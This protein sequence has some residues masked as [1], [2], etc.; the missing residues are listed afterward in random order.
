MASN[1]ETLLASILSAVY[2]KDVRQSI[3]DAIAQCYDDVSN[4]DL[5]SEAFIKAI[6]EKIDDGSIAK[7]TLANGAVTTELLADGSVTTAKIAVGAVTPDEIKDRS[8][9]TNKLADG[10]VTEEKLADGAVTAKKIADGTI[11]GSKFLDGSVSA[12][13][14]AN[15]SV[16]TEKL[17]N[18]AVTEEKLAD[19]AVGSGKL[20]AGSVTEEK[21][22]DGAVESGKL[23]AGSVTTEKVKDGAI[24][25]EKLASSFRERIKDDEKD[26]EQLQSNVKS[27]TNNITLLTQ[28][29]NNFANGFTIGEDGK[30]YLTH[31]G[32]I[33][34]NG[35]DIATGGSG[36]AGLAFNGGYMSEDGYLHLTQDGE[37]IDGFDPIYIGT[38]GGGAA[39]SKLVFA[40]YTAS[41]FSVLQTS[42]TAPIKFRFSSVDAT[43]QTETGAGN[44]SIYVGGILKENRTVDQGDNISI[45]V[46]E[47]LAAGSNTVKLVMTD[48]YG[49]TATRTLAITLESF[50]LEWNLGKTEKNSGPLVVYVTPTGSGT[51]RIYLLVDGTQTEMQEVTTTG[52]R[53]S[54]SVPLTI[55]AH[56]ISV[57]GT[58]TI[59][60]VTLT[61][62]TLTCAVA[63]TDESDDTVVIAANLQIE[64]TE[65]YSTLSIPYRVIDPKN[66]PT[67]VTFY[68]DEVE[69]ASDEVDQSEHV[70]SYRTTKSGTLTLGIACGGEEWTKTIEVTAL[71]SEIAEVTDNLVLKVDPNDITDLNAF[72]YEGID[73]SFS[74]N[75]DTHNGGLQTDEEGIRCIKV[76]KGDR[77]V[78]NYNLFGTDARLN[79]RAFKFIYKIMNCSDFFAEAITCINGNIGLSI[80]ANDVAVTTEQTSIALETCE[81]YKTELELNIEPDSENRIMMMWE[82]GV[83]SAAK[84]Y[85][86][87]DNLKQT[88][89]VGITVGSDYCDVF[90]YL[91]RVYSRDLTKEEIKANYYAD[92]KDAAEITSRYDRNQVY[93]GSGKL[94]PDK[95]AALNPGVHV[96][97]WHAS[98]VSTAKSQEIT[99]SLTHKYVKGG[100]SH[101]WTAENVV[102]KAQGTSSLGYVDAGCNED[103]NLKEG[104]TLEDG[105]HQDVYS[106]TDDSIGVSYFNFKTNVASQE[107]INNIMVADHYNS[108][109]PYTRWAK[110]VNGKV[111]DTVEGHMAVMFFHNTGTAAVQVG[112]YTVQPDETI[113][114][115]L[116]NLNNSKKNYEVFG[117][118]DE[119]DIYCIEVLNNISAQCRFKSDDL[120]TE[121]WDGEGNFE[122][123]YISETVSKEAA[124]ANFQKLLSF[125]VSCDKD[126][127][128]NTA[129]DVVKTID[130]QSFVADTAEYRMAKWKAEAPNYFVMESVKYHEVETLVICMPDSQS[131]NVFITWSNKEQKWHF[132]N[133]YDDDTSMG[134]DNEGGLTLKYGYMKDDKIGTKNVFNAADNTIWV[135]T[136]ACFQDELKELYID[137][138]N[139]GAWDLDG[140]ADLCDSQ[141]ELACESLWIEDV[142]RKDI[143]TLINLGQPGYVPMLNGKKRLQRRKF[144]HFQRAFMSSYFIGSYATGSSG[145]I[146][147]YTPTEYAG[148]KPESK[149][150][151]TPYCDLWVTVKAGS[152]TVQKR[153]TAGEAVELSL[154]VSSMNDTEIYVRNAGFIKDLGDL[155]CLYPGYIDIAELKK[156]Q[157]LQA[158]SSIE[159]Y[160]NTNMTGVS[161]TNAKS[162]EYV[163]V[164]NC[165]NL[166][167]ELDLSNNVSVKECYTRGSGVTGVSF[168]DWGRLETAYLNAL[169]SIYANNLQYVKEF[170]LEAYDKL[171]TL[172]ISGS[173]SLDSLGIAMKAE[174][175][176]RVRLI[177][178]AWR[179][180]VKAYQTLMR[181][182]NANGIDDDGH[183]TDVGVVK[184]SCY[185]DSI[186]E[187]KYK[188]LVNALSDVVF[189]YGEFLEEHTVT[190]VNYD[191][192]V[193]NTQKVEQG[194]TAEDPITYG[195]IGTPTKPSDDDYVYTYYKWDT[196]LENIVAD[197]TIT[198]TYTQTTRIN[199]V[200]YLQDGTVLEIHQVQAHGSCIYEGED[201]TKSG[202]VWTGWDAIAEDVVADMDINA[203]FIYPKLPDTVKDLAKYDYAYSDDPD[204]TSAYTFGELYSIY[205]MGRA[206]EY[207]LDES[208]VIKMIPTTAIKKG[209]IT[210]TSIFFR[211]HSIGHYALSDGSAMSNGDFYMV[212]VL[213]SNRQMNSTNT[214][215][216]GWDACALRKWLNET[217]YPAL[218][219]R[220]RNFI[221]LSDTLASAG[222]QSAEIL[223]SQDRLRIPAQAEVGFDVAA[224]PY[225]D[226]ISAEAKEV[227]FSC[228]TD[229]SS[230]IKKTFN[231]EGAAQNWWLRSADP[232]GAVA[233]RAVYSYGSSAT[234]TANNSY[235]VCVGFSV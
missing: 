190:F 174:N 229:N 221:A 96:L 121:T 165:P 101:S 54:F 6:Q 66:N 227:T 88:S 162:L 93:D 72:E 5:N 74:E 53:I 132:N 213:A 23:A 143:D 226:E 87:N 120:S 133:N 103:F 20:A 118:D 208:T 185:F 150:T 55:G 122:F 15:G 31:D 232:G 9:E 206:S 137:R 194:G 44:L 135:M 222:S 184:G 8:V 3:H 123:R 197:V 22:A 217:L 41:T 48:S 191:G 7:M 167:Q 86:V 147:G 233:F 94:D 188:V 228:Y 140:F 145:T 152:G 43:T 200:R 90:I 11:E 179:T 97:T 4:P 1:I 198:A 70:W 224:V 14:L 173:Q 58:M 195:Y 85:A 78:I 115:S 77:M 156:L 225:K 30:V 166:A 231:G 18:G 177:D 215:V 47:Y 81:G 17:V 42:G 59:N 84:V 95:V 82:K 216:G 36:G 108:Y 214:N 180:T 60:G 37:D 71:S 144:L 230:R 126:N 16:G 109:Q 211:H 27:L 107:H 192:T 151:I 2:G 116:G 234:S 24:T 155:A 56:V 176:N 131:K 35:L 201:L 161:V 169:S 119:D 136:R 219:P 204:D 210:D 127:A 187:T 10:A 64:E 172:N 112:P 209:I 129:F 157:R 33:V 196:P 67:A 63:E 79:G 102:Q 46:F 160:S 125:V 29:T 80:K 114:Y 99:G 170:T 203:T 21:L 182:H 159:G 106:M 52:R 183:N 141:Q 186:S 83:P 205:K 202:Y 73:L 178:V 13:K 25:T 49:A 12:K 68:V 138:E 130:G 32:T 92:G 124:V 75:F 117:Q 153:A 146:R 45:D 110:T 175:I 62:E 57:Y 168:A 51:K 113:F 171:T 100:A 128:T 189:T 50:T 207:G 149:M 212:G 104:I 40:M 26:I 193:L 223:T 158:G 38:V 76:M 98:N 218:E 65:Q 220:W 154:G 105:T 111:R 28:S 199:T 163:N 181:L 235:G 39:G 89:P 34:S 139:A 134:T 148:V 19:G 69:Y 142:Y 61:S 164:E 91:V